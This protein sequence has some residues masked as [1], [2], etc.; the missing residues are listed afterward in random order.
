MKTGAELR[1]RGIKMAID[2]AEYDCPNWKLKARFALQEFI[3]GNP[4]R[5]FQAEDVRRWAYRNGLPRAQNDRA[6][7]W[8]MLSA[9]RRGMIRFVGY[10]PVTNLTA[11]RTPAA[12]W[13]GR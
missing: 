10:K 12:V 4:G 3:K 1:D 13:Q 11:H 9:K 6:W 8:I 2:G 7:G 5:K